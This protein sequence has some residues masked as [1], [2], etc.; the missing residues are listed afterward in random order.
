MKFVI[1]TG[2]RDYLNVDKVFKT[3]D[4]LQPDRV[5]EGGCPTGADAFARKWCELNK[6]NNHTVHAEW[7][8]HG[9]S[10][11]P[12]RNKKM[13]E[14]YPNATVVAFTGGRGTANCVDIANQMNMLVVK[15][16]R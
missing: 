14:L 13:L 4:F 15:V 12:L 3:L 7:D 1:V 11:G 6:V 5:I 8:R 16:E 2:G 10:A 9:K